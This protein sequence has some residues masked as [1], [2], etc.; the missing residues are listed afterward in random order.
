MLA[1]RTSTD[2]EECEWLWKKAWP[3]THFFDLWPVRQCFAS[4]FKRKPFFIVAEQN[5]K[6]AGL[7]AL[8]WIEEGGYFGHFPGEIWG[9][10]T[11]LEQNRIP[12]RSPEVMRQ[13][14][15][16]IPGPAHLRYLSAESFSEESYPLAVDEVGYFFY[17][18]MYSYSFQEYM[19]QFSGKSRKQ[20]AK[21]RSHLESFG[22]NYSY[23]HFADVDL[24]FEMNVKAFGEMSYFSDSR[25][26][27][28]F[29]NLVTWLKKNNMLR[30]T[31]LTIGSSVAAID[32]GALWNK[33]YTVMAGGTD[34]GFPGVAKMINFHHMEWACQQRL[35]VVDFLCG[36]FGWK[37]RFHLSSRPLYE[38]NA[39]GL[40]PQMNFQDTYLE[41]VYA[42]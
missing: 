30:I 34:R 41:Q 26:L 29:K 40:A 37:K 32:I 3:Q 33:T 14:L 35:D 2:S 9:G 24:L 16:S 4:G 21:E 20:L 38:I 31:T 11:W 39:L 23:D 27:I 15:A 28:S 13:L 7:L 12:A 5:D 22:V 18:E 17:P 6:I 8:S 25:F 36:D 1:I 19:K 42:K 10:K